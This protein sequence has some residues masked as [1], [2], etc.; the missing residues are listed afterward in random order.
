MR[1]SPVAVPP[2]PPNMLAIA[3]TLVPALLAHRTASATAAQRQ[4]CP[5]AEDL[6][7][8]AAELCSGSPAADALRAVGV[9]PEKGARVPLAAKLLE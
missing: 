5:A 8:R 4:H 3:A 7:E 9:L 2:A 6:A 1:S